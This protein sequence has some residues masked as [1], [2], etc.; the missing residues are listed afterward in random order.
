MD[1][2]RQYVDEYAEMQEHMSGVIKYTGLSA[3]AV[4]EL[5]ESFKG[6]DTR[7]SRA[8]LNDLAADAGRLGIQSKHEVLDFVDAANQITVTLGEDIGDDAVK[9]IGKITQ[10]FQTDPSASLKD[11]M[12]ATAST[13]N[14]L[15]QSSSA[16]EPYLLEF[17]ARLSG[18]A[19]SAKISQTD[20]FGLAS[21][22]DQSMVGVE[23]GATAMQNVLGALFRKP[24]QMAKI[25]GLNVKEFTSLLQNDANAALLQFLQ[26]LKDKGG[27]ENVAPLLEQMKLSGADM[28]QTHVKRQAHFGQTLTCI[29]AISVLTLGDAATFSGWKPLPTEREQKNVGRN[30]IFFPRFFNLFPLVLHPLPRFWAYLYEVLGV[31]FLQ[32]R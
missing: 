16:S 23:K 27:M 13:I 5:Y 21:V 15:A 8:Q 2:M 31:F 11:G 24:A 6:L 3:E 9:N 30:R 26:A 10:L 1:T 22:L 12:L 29:C 32:K 20:I 19:N 7:T 28:T 25:A 4:D 18:M 14:D 17:T